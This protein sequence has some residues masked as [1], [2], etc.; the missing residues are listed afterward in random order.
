MEWG[1]GKGIFVPELIEI[2]SVPTIKSANLK[3]MRYGDAL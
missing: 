1:N 2:I 3:D